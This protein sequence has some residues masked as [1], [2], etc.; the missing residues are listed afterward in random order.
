MHCSKAKFESLKTSSHVKTCM[1]QFMCFGELII[2]SHRRSR[3]FP[4][5]HSTCL[6]IS[7]TPTLPPKKNITQNPKNYQKRQQKWY[8]SWVSQLPGFYTSMSPA[9]CGPFSTLPAGNDRLRGAW[10]KRIP[11]RGSGASPKKRGAGRASRC[12]E[13]PEWQL[14][15]ED[16][17]PG[18]EA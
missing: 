16:G 8:A 13:A 3:T 12:S 11:G 5:L 7:S 2:Q 4:F 15:L 10:P 18:L 14:A 6:N 9:R 17:S 1:A